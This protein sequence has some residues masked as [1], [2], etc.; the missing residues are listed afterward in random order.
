MSS[1]IDIQI[2]STP[3]LVKIEN[4]LNDSTYRETIEY[5]A[6]F[7]TRLCIERR[8]RLPF[9]DPQTGVAQNHC[10]LFMDRTQRMPGF[11]EGQIYS[12]PAA[13]WRKS[14]RQYLTKILRPFGALRH[15]VAVAA[16]TS[17][18]TSINS[19]GGGGVVAGNTGISAGIGAA[20]ISAS[21][22]AASKRGIDAVQIPVT[23]TGELSSDNDFNGSGFL[24]ESSSLGGADTSDSKDS[25]HIKDD[26]PKEW[27]YDDMDINEID[28]LEEPKSPADDEYDYDPR[29]GN[30]KRKKRKPGRKASL[31]QTHHHVGHEGGGPRKGRPPGGGGGGVG[32]GRGRRKN[33]NSSRTVLNPPSPGP[34]SEPPS[35]ETAAAAVEHASNDD[36]SS[37]DLRSYRKYL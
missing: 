23:V 34:I 7:N 5:S 1:A 29:Y 9:L 3:N 24:E 10:S 22:L 32:R 36:S 33:Q 15:A 16:A 37:S 12:Y 21:S 6:N 19:S 28:G 26:L 13:R 18:N 2:V 8:L 35:F 27:F 4:F 14:R 17:S 25:Q 30:K 11:R 20:A 31:P